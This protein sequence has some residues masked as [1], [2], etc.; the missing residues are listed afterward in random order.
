VVVTAWLYLLDHV[1][2]QHTQTVTQFIRRFITDYNYYNNYIAEPYAMYRGR[3]QIIFGIIKKGI[4]TIV[5][6]KITIECL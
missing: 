1:I 3:E 6:C 4:Q 5:D 2:L